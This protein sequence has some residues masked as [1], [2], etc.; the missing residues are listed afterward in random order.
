EPKVPDAAA[1]ANDGNAQKADFAKLPFK[2]SLAY[3]TANTMM[4]VLQTKSS[5]SRS[6]QC[7][8]A[9]FSYTADRSQCAFVA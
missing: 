3:R 2:V 8:A 4:V 5:L 9:V 6:S 7:C 1:R